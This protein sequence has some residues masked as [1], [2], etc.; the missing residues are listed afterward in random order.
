[1]TKPRLLMNRLAMNSFLILDPTAEVQ[2]QKHQKSLLD[3][4]CS[5]QEAK[6]RLLMKRLKMNSFLIP[7][8]Q[9]L[10]FESI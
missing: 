2:T 4:I 8:T 3:P 5:S 6:P 7:Q 9:W 10:K 1:M